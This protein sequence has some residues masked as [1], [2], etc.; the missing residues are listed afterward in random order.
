MDLKHLGFRNF[1]AGVQAGLVFL[2]PGLIL[3]PQGLFQNVSIALV[4]EVFFRGYL[5]PCFGNLVTSALFTL[6][7]LVVKPNFGSLLVLFPSLL[8]GYLYLRT[9][10]L[11]A[12]ILAHAGMNLLFLWSVEEFP[13][14]HRLLQT[15]LA[16]G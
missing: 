11:L 2:I 14:L 15:D 7:H 9:G 3:Y 16:W 13:D 10:S 1:R 5:M 6:A 8:L 4:E 12:P